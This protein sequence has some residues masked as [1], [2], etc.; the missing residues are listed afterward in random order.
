M[1]NGATGLVELCSGKRG[2]QYIEDHVELGAPKS[3][4]VGSGRS[5]RVGNKNHIGC[6]GCKKRQCQVVRAGVVQHGG[7]EHRLSMRLL[8]SAL[9]LITCMTM[10]KRHKLY[11][12]CFF[13]SKNITGLIVTP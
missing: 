7:Q 13:I 4:G 5:F 1:Q 11:S 9:P 8:K 2:C 10:G 12:L 3:R 6:L